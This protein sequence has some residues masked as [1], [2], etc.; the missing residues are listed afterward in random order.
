MAAK[1]T[2]Q[3]ECGEW[4]GGTVERGGVGLVERVGIAE[5]GAGAGRGRRPPARGQGCRLGTGRVRRD[6]VETV[7]CMPIET[8]SVGCLAGCVHHSLPALLSETSERSLLLQERQQEIA[9]YVVPPWFMVMSADL[10]CA[11]LHQMMSR[12]A[13]PAIDSEIECPFFNIFF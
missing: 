7:L 10:L 9:V 8:G 5:E 4:A 13:V 12:V 6:K 1:R 3:V 2:A 11:T